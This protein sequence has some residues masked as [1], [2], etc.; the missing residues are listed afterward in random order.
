MPKSGPTVV[1]VQRKIME[2]EF[3]GYARIVNHKHGFAVLQELVESEFDASQLTDDEL[4]RVVSVLKD[5]AHLPP[6]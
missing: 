4:A 3:Q 5:M 2:L 1:N 6:A